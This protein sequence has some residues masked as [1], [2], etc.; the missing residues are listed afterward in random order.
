[1]FM[2]RIY[3]AAGRLLYQS[4]T[5]YASR[6]EAARVPLAQR[7]PNKRCSGPIYDHEWRR[8]DGR[9]LSLA[10]KRQPARQLVMNKPDASRLDRPPRDHQRTDLQFQLC[11]HADLTEEAPMT[12][13]QASLPARK[14]E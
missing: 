7:P 10:R 3:S 2:A 1:M 11:L 8:P 5:A 9:W 13:L 14:T 4:P 12:S 6:G